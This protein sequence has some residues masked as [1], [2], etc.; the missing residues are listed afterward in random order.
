MQRSDGAEGA[1][2]LGRLVRTV[3]AL[4]DHLRRLRGQASHTAHAVST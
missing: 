3:I 2:V 1:G 4:A